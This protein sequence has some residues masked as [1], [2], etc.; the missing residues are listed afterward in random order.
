MISMN[1]YQQQQ[2]EALALAR[3]ALSCLRIAEM[4][5]LKAQIRDYLQW[6]QTVDCF[7]STH[8]SSRCTQSCYANHRSACC[9]KDGIITFWADVVINL[10]CS[11]PRQITDLENALNQPVYAFKCTYLGP[12]G[13]RWQVRPLGCVMFLCDEAQQAVFGAR[14]A[15][16]EQWAVLNRAAKAF[17]WPDQPVLFDCIETFFIER[18]CRS[19]LMYINTSPGLMRIKQQAGLPV[20]ADPQQRRSQTL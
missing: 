2:W 5:G 10:L 20:Y 17:R 18:G 15:L 6:R 16:E 3:T 11:N 19:P 4:D 9:G 12:R 1:D 13:C 8:F 7:L 14:S